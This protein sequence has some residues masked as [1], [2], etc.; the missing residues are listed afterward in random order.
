MITG[1]TRLRRAGAERATP[2]QKI[3]DSD[4]RVERR[5]R[6]SAGRFRRDSGAETTQSLRS[7]CSTHSVRSASSA[8][9]TTTRNSVDTSSHEISDGL[10]GYATVSIARCLASF[11]IPGA[12]TPSMVDLTAKAFPQL[13]VLHLAAKPRCT[14]RGAA[15][16]PPRSGVAPAAKRRCTCAR[17]ARSTSARSAA[18]NTDVENVAVLA[19]GCRVATQRDFLG[20]VVGTVIEKGASCP[21]DDHNPG[22][23][24]I[25][26]GR[27]NAGPS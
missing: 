1:G 17:R 6:R 13:C 24:V 16:H 15:L 22:R 4:E 2:S 19:C 26:P 27:E 21:R 14:R 3:E 7:S 10:G 9:S 23:V 12:A 8:T 5:S 25:M 18:Y 11:V 20:R